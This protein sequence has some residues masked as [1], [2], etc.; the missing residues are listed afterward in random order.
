[1]ANEDLTDVFK[2]RQPFAAIT[3][4][5]VKQTT[6]IVFFELCDYEWAAKGYVSAILLFC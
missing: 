2:D 3:E 5:T 4:L 6:S 1:M